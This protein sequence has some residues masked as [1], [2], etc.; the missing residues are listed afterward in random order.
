MIRYKSSLPAGCRTGTRSIIPESNVIFSY[1]PF[2]KVMQRTEVGLVWKNQPLSL[3]DV[4]VA[5]GC[6]Y[7]MQKCQKVEV[8]RS[9]RTKENPLA[10]LRF[11]CS[12]VC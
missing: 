2:N 1:V 12:N 4:N 10:V 11:K 6:M 5:C 3:T 7:P 8:Y 9:T